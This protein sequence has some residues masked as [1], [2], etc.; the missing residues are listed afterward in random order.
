MVALADD[1]GDVKC[2]Y[3]AVR[4]SSSSSTAAARE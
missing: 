1:L 3:R 4:A 2:N